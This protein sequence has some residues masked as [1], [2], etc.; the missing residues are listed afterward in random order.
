MVLKSTFLAAA[1]DLDEEEEEED[2]GLTSAVQLFGHTGM[3][4]AEKNSCYK[5]ISLWKIGFCVPVK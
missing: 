5:K 1:E 3:Y 2:E 4:K